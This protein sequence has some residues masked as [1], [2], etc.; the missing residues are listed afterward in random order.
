MVRFAGS[1]TAPA[2]RYLMSEMGHGEKRLP[3]PLRDR[4]DAFPVDEVRDHIDRKAASAV[5]LKRAQDLL[6]VLDVAADERRE[7]CT[8]YVRAL[9]RR[10]DAAGKNWSDPPPHAGEELFGV[11]HE[12][13]GRLRERADRAMG[14]G[15]AWLSNRRVSFRCRTWER[16]LPRG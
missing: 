1:G 13:R 8:V 11:L 16:R 2:K 5:E 4:L 9:Y 10:L 7:M 3:Q 6:E 14:S 12:D 15:T